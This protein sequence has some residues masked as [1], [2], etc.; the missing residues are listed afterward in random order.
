[1]LHLFFAKNPAKTTLDHAQKNAAK[2]LSLSR[3]FVFV[4]PAT[5]S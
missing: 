3:H 5:Y 4:S 2:A 1:M